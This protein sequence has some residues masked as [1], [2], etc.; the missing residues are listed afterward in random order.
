MRGDIFSPLCVRRTGLGARGVRTTG[1]G[2]RVEY[3]GNSSYIH[4]S[5]C[6]DFKGCQRG[7]AGARGESRGNSSFIHDFTRKGF[8]D[9]VS[10]NPSIFPCLPALNIHIL[11]RKLQTIP[12][13]AYYVQSGLL[14]PVLL[15]RPF[16]QASCWWL[17]YFFA[18]SVSPKLQHLPSTHSGNFYCLLC[19]TELFSRHISQYDRNQWIRSI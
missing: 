15:Q 9:A 4:D 5:T 8:P 7:W 17:T 11:S 13:D 10:P 18:E 6:K 12:P 14:F 19:K 1:L 3:R 2:A 16:Y